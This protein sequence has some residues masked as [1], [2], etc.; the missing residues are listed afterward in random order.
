MNQSMDWNLQALKAKKDF[1]DI[2]GTDKIGWMAPGEAAGADAD[3]MGEKNSFT[4]Q[5]A[6]YQVVGGRERK[7]KGPMPCMHV[8]YTR[9]RLVARA[10][11]TQ[12]HAR[13]CTTRQYQWETLASLPAPGETARAKKKKNMDRNR[14][15]PPRPLRAIEGLVQ[16]LVVVCTWPGSKP[17]ACC[18]LREPEQ[19]GL[20]VG[21]RGP[22][23]GRWWATVG[24]AS[25]QALSIGPRALEQ[26]AQRCQWGAAQRPRE[27]HGSK[28][29]MLPFH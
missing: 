27:G 2:K 20:Q 7:E 13:P 16:V 22:Q 5:N 3:W 24:A 1:N 4:G 25:A 23:R 18:N 29:S 12:V 19:S 10:R 9:G 21:Y 6:F 28:G 26:S 15:P 8:L 17:V 14:E 11:Y